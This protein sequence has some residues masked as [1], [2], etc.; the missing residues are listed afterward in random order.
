MEGRQ[1][2]LDKVDIKKLDYN[3]IHLP[4]LVSGMAMM[5]YGLRDFDKDV[6]L[7]ISEEDHKNLATKL[8][9]E[10]TILEGD[11]TVGY[12]KKPEFVDLY[13]D[14]GILIYEFEIWDSIYL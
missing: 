7:I 4:L 3:F 5:Y 9:D 2:V 10:A 1:K 13:D 14:H 11:S 6:D 12:K 8:I